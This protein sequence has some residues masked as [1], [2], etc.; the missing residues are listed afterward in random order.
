MITIHWDFTDGTEVS[1]VTGKVLQDN[2][3][4]CCLEFFDMNQPCDD[5]IVLRRDG[6]RI[7][8][9]NIQLSTSKEIR[10]EH[11][12]RKLLVSGVLKFV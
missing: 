11:N 2:F 8:R 1:Y 10:P 5:V 7:S 4:T 9:N 12:I 3:T 6:R